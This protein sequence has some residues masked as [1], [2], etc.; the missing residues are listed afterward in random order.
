MKKTFTLT[1]L[2]LASVIGAGFASGKEIEVFFT[3]YKM[4]GYIG[5]LFA[6][7]LFIFVFKLFLLFGNLYRPKNFFDAIKMLFG[8]AYKFVS[9]IVLI[10][11]F[12]V[13]AGMF[14]GM[15]EVF[16]YVFNI[17]I[18]NV[19]VLIFL[20]LVSLQNGK[21]M[22]VVNKVNNFFIPI[23]M[24]VL[25]V[26]ATLTIKTSNFALENNAS[27]YFGSLNSAV[28]YVGINI[29]LA[30]SMLICEGKNYTKNNIKSAS[31]LSAFVLFLIILLFNIALSNNHFTS[32]MPMVKLSFSINY[33]VGL[34]TLICVLF[35]IYS[36]ISSMA[37]VVSTSVFKTINGFKANA[38]VCL[39]S[40]IISLFGFNKI[41]EF[42]YPIIGV[43]GIIFSVVL[44]V[45]LQKF[46]CKNK[47]TMQLNKNGFIK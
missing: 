10:C 45:K 16:L 33:Y 22:G 17:T 19:M 32:S 23:T 29:L 8:K 15:Y 40:Y 14:A 46:M 7:I 2:I 20:V 11:Y 6:F 18:S 9:V 31:F 25:V 26:V 5:I 36:S 3:K 41:V 37:F 12:I 1:C 4:C 47:P 28:R 24:C 13:L 44:Y 34:L 38:V 21:G 42:L 27:T 30:G 35:A 39:I 43:V